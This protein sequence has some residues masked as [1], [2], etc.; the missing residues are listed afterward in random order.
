MLERMCVELVLRNFV[1][2]HGLASL[3]ARRVNI[4]LWGDGGEQIALPKSNA[5]IFV[6]QTFVLQPSLYLGLA[7]TYR[8][9]ARERDAC[10]IQTL[11]NPINPLI[12]FNPST[13]PITNTD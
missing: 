3:I 7:F 6:L 4:E 13:N 9:R 12:L 1:R 10:T 5:Q 8:A 2:S 11:A